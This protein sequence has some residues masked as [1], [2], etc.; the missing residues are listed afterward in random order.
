MYNVRTWI[1]TCCTCG[2]SALNSS[3]NLDV[4]RE[5]RDQLINSKHGPE[6]NYGQTALEVLWVIFLRN[7]FRKGFANG[8]RFVRRLVDIAQNLNT[9]VNH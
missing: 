2:Y 3:D 4:K 9:P 7:R 5:V 1:Q 6:G 8:A